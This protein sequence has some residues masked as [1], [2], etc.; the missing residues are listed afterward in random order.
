[1][2]TMRVALVQIEAR[3]DVADNLSRA[4]AMAAEAAVDSDLVILPEY[5]QF[6]GSAAGFRASA[7]P[8]PGPTTEPFEAVAREHGCWVLAGSHAEASGDP[9]RPYNTA[10]LLDRS[11][12]LAATYRKLHLFDVA[13]DDGPADN[14]SARV[15]AGDRAVVVSVDGVGLGLS[16]CYDLR[17]PELYRALAGAGAKL[18]AVPA[19][20]TERTG[21][22]HWEVLLRSRAI[23]N[24]AW[25]LAA[26]ACGPGGPRA[27]P[28]WGHSM[29]VDPWGHVIA[30]AGSGEAIV[31]AEI[32]LGLVDAARR[33]IPALANR[34][35]DALPPVREVEVVA[36]DAAAR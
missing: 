5:V 13:V 35:P 28:A 16:I 7:A 25:V 36:I 18:L 31:R 10:V 24:G 11:G 6:R 23:E 26:G 1:M 33:Q 17:F 19:V 34:R 9:D 12:A 14:E 8:I 30:S 2:R 15:M 32:D 29:V 27:I 22:D 21:R 3:D 4:A 20:F